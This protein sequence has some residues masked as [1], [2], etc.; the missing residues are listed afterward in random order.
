MFSNKGIIDFHSAEFL[1]DSEIESCSVITK[2]H[3]SGDIHSG[4]ASVKRSRTAKLI[5][6]IVQ[7]FVLEFKPWPSVVLATKVATL[8]ASF[9]LVLLVNKNGHR[10]LEPFSVCRK[11]P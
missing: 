7:G 2:S 8:E 3:N 9:M 4:Q 10:Y 5:A 11:K 6:A 1:V